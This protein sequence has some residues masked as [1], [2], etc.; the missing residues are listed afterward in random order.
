MDGQ[1]LAA[2]LT[3]VGFIEPVIDVDRVDVTYPS[4]DRLV[5]DLREMGCTNVLTERSRRP[6][7]RRRLDVARGA[8]LSGG[9]SVVERFELLHFVAWTPKQ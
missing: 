8:F 5:G 4:F 2:L 7:T 3:S 9:N 1:S 6:I